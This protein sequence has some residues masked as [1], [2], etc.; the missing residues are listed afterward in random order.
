MSADR[1]K[2]LP[3]VTDLHVHIQPW[4]QMKPDVAA[5]MR[6]G[7]EDHWDFL[8]QIME[9]PAALLEIMDRADIWR[10]GLINYPSQDL[11]GFTDETNEF[12]AKY[13][14][15]TCQEV[16]HDFEKAFQ[17]ARKCAADFDWDAVVGNRVYVWTGL[18]QANLRKKWLA[19]M[20]QSQLR[21]PLLKKPKL[22]LKE[23][24]PLW[25]IP[26]PSPWMR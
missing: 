9:D 25:P 1:S 4:S 6:R 7:K 18:T 11:M 16:T 26:I 23:I 21:R 20:M 15:Y 22:L 17:A 3:G 5:V 14:G 10:V 24:Q 8:I 13:A 2:T 12:A 19:N